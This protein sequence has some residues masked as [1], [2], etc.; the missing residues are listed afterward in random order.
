MEPKIQNAVL[1][2]LSKEEGVSPVE[3]WT[4]ERVEETLY[5]D[6]AMI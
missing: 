4:Q 6:D 5:D 3:D 1:Q 2:N